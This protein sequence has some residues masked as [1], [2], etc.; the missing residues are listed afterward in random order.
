ME[1]GY[2]GSRIYMLQSAPHVTGHS[3]PTW[4]LMLKS[5]APVL[6]LITSRSPHAHLTLTSHS[7][8][9]HSRTLH[10]RTLHAHL[11]HPPYPLTLTGLKRRGAVEGCALHA[12]GR[13]PP[14]KGVQ[15]GAREPQVSV[16]DAG[17]AAGGSTPCLE[18]CPALPCIE[19]CVHYLSLE[20]CLALPCTERC[21]PCATGGGGVER[22]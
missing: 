2:N 5:L 16:P 20:Q 17:G 11:A 4:L 21:T 7:L 3:A 18:Q 14:S 22:V 8:T 19:R 1:Q 15:E 13:H 6:A 12:G 9:S 10:S